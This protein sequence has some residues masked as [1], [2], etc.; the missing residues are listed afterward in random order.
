M[1]PTL[2]VGTSVRDALRRRTLPESQRTQSV[3]G[4]VATRS[5][6]TING[7]AAVRFSRN[8]LALYA[9]GTHALRGH[10]LSRR[11]ASAD[12]A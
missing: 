8:V 9:D 6:G 4:C 2:C 5:V 7:W 12:S 10:L 3:L 11:S 1:V